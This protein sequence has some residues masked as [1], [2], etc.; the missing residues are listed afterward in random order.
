MRFLT[1][2]CL[3]ALLLGVAGCGGGGGN[4]APVSNP[5]TNPGNDG[6]GSSGTGKTGIGSIGTG[7][8]TGTGS[9]GTGPIPATSGGKAFAATD[10]AVFQSGY[11]DSVTMGVSATR[12]VA[13]DTQLDFYVT[14]TACALRCFASS[15]D[16]IAASVD[17][18]ALQTYTPTALNAWITLTL[19]TGLPDTPHH[20]TVKKANPT[21]TLLLDSM[22][23]IT[24]QGK[25]PALIRPAD[26]DP[27]NWGA[28]QI[29]LVASDG[30][31]TTV[32][33]ADEAQT[34]YFRAQLSGYPNALIVGT[35]A[36]G[37]LY[38][39]ATGSGVRLWMLQNGS[40][41]QTT[42]DGVTQ[43]VISVANTDQFGWVTLASGL[44]ANATHT[45]VLT[46]VLRTNTYTTLYALMFPGGALVPQTLPARP[47]LA[48]TGHSFVAGEFGLD[49]SQLYYLPLAQAHG[50]AIASRGFGG[51]TFLNTPGSPS[52]YSTNSVE[53]RLPEIVAVQPDICVVDAFVNDVLIGN[54]VSPPETPE[55]LQ[56]GLQDYLTQ[57]LQQC[58][59]T[60]F[61]ILGLLDNTGFESRLPPFI[62]AI[63]AAVQA[64]NSPRCTFVSETG[65]I[66]PT[67]DTFSDG[68]HPN[69]Q[70]NQKIAAHLAPIL[71][72]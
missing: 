34:L 28:Q 40:R 55:R 14:G 57:A 5:V 58:P 54:K 8:S 30:K 38:C 72:P 46:N 61:Y 10:P 60:H 41:W 39:R 23:A 37:S 67:T 6:T 25:A 59:N 27:V 20:V 17:G 3:L 68:L 62:A 70:G 66:D 65:W 32:G 16:A 35:Y 22:Q 42:V 4:T 11:F 29:P 56:A 48:V 24:V 9:G 2:V 69:V 64:Q 50:Y 7:V 26:A 53:A 15:N 43:P 71:F 1:G 45:Y 49:L 19:F 31:S 52:P 47:I 12:F 21:A 13:Q 36:G 51:V 33:I 18:G 63:Q 44:N